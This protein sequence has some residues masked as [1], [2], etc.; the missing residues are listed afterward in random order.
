MA[1][2]KFMS[3]SRE[4]F[5]SVVKSALV[6]PRYGAGAPLASFPRRITAPKFEKIAF[7]L[8]SVVLLGLSLA[9]CSD[10]PS[11][12]A[13]SEEQTSETSGAAPS[14]ENAGPQPTLA[15]SASRETVE[16]TGDDSAGECSEGT[17][18]SV[19]WRALEGGLSLLYEW[20]HWHRSRHREVHKTSPEFGSAVYNAFL[21]HWI[22]AGDSQPVLQVA[23]PVTWQT[24]GMTCT[25]D[26]YSVLCT[27]GDEAKV[28]IYRPIPDSV[29]KP[30]GLQY[31]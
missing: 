13:S 17:D 20:A 1:D 15:T 28:Y 4:E 6:V 29:T 26:A 2:D 10:G 5:V 22:A 9:A 24:Y 31:E 21:D 30:W 3:L 12:D 25:E 11:S 19:D 7:A 14:S 8:S 23:S 16:P 18:T 27:G